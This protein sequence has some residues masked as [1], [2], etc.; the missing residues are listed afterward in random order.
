MMDQHTAKYTS[1]LY[2]QDANC[3]KRMSNDLSDLKTTL[4]K[5]M[6]DGYSYLKGMIVDNETGELVYQINNYL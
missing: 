3:V 4:V 1:K 6:N 2:L 5:R